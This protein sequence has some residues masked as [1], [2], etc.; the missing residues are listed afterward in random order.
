MVGAA[1]MRGRGARLAAA[2]NV[3]SLIFVVVL[4][5]VVVHNAFTYPSASGFDAEGYREYART[6][7]EEWLIPSAGELRNYYTPP[8]FFL[9]AARR[10]SNEPWR[11]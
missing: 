4:A 2:P 5:L 1:A 3:L 6:V 11:A 9:L 8:G 7:I 10:G